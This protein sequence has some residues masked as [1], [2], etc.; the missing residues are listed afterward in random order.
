MSYP[1]LG[2]SELQRRPDLT[3]T[4]VCNPETGCGRTFVG[5]SQR[6]VQRL[7]AEH[8]DEVLDPTGHTMEPY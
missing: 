4:T 2:L 6:D 8:L 3:E 7:F 5:R 1:Y